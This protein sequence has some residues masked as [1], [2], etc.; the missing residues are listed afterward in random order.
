MD[1]L[2][3]YSNRV[4]LP[5]VTDAGPMTATKGVKTELVYNLSDDKVY[6]CTVT[7]S[8]ATWAALN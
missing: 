3:G 1:G 8:P 4:M 2:F 5:E 7:G 6:V